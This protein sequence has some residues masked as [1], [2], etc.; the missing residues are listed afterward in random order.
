VSIRSAPGAGTTFTIRLPFTVS[1]SRALMVQVG[2]DDLLA[3]PLNG[4]EGIVRITPMA[5]RSTSR[6]APDASLLLR[7]PALRL[8][9]PRRARSGAT[10]PPSRTDAI[11]VPVH[12]RALRRD[13]AMALVH[14]DR[15]IAGSREIVVKGLGPQFAGVGGIS[16]ATILGDGSVVVILDLAG[17]G[18][19]TRARRD[20]RRAGGPGGGPVRG[21]T[22]HHARS[23]GRG[24]AAVAASGPAESHRGR[25]RGRR[26]HGRGRLGD[27]TQGHVTA[28]AAPGLSRSAVAKDGVDAVA[29]LTERRSPTSCS[30]TS[31]C[32][33]MDGF[34]VATHVRGDR[35]LSGPADRDDHVAH[36]EPSTGSAPRRSA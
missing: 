14:V 20:G 1:V 22:Q 21:G 8:R 26:V 17:P 28:A 18:A 13:L 27:R 7:R 35:E 33:A 34:E 24:G 32:R 19:R 3:V 25:G 31:R 11:S 4:I 5:A 6:D 29:A 23:A 2:D 9:L 15:A 30:S 12:H 16:G 10:T 36:G